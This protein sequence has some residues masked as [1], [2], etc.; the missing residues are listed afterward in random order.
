MEALPEV[1]AT[2]AGAFAEGFEAA[3]DGAALDG[4][5]LAAGAAGDLE[6]L[7][8]TFR[9]ALAGEVLTGALAGAFLRAFEGALAATGF[10]LLA[11]V[12]GFL[13]ETFAGAGFLA[14][15]GAFPLFRDF[16][17]G[18]FLAGAM[19]L[20]FFP[21]D[22]RAGEGLVDFFNGTELVPESRARKDR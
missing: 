18:A 2:G 21:E 22:F 6:T 7:A 11:G 10:A 12:S 3:L 15:E 13:A 8:A 14:G 19:D 4:A 17:G 9:G 20:G 16:P 1:F 5:D